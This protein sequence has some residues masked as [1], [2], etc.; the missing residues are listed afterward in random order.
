MMQPLPKHILDMIM[1]GSENPAVAR[2]IANWFRIPSSAYN[3]FFHENDIHQN[4]WGEW[5]IR[6][7]NERH[8]P[9][10]RSLGVSSND[11]IHQCCDVC[12]LTKLPHTVAEATVV[13]SC[14]AIRW[15]FVHHPPRPWHRKSE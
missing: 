14:D 11:G 9:V 15:P 7:R 12:G 8:P 6:P 5:Y 1:K 13:D 4:T 10:N 2:R 3:D